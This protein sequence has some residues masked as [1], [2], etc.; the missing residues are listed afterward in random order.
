MGGFRLI[1]LSCGPENLSLQSLTPIPPFSERMAPLSEQQLKIQDRKKKK[2]YQTNNPEGQTLLLSVGMD[3][4][5]PCAKLLPVK[6]KMQTTTWGWGNDCLLNKTTLVP[7]PTEN[8]VRL[9]VSRFDK[10]VAHGWW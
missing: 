1:A 9:L 4:G 2:K 10:P 3:G 6:K 7:F 8:L 5:W